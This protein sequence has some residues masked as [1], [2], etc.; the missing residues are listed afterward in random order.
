MAATVSL[1]VPLLRHLLLACGGIPAENDAVRRSLREGGRL[2]IVP[3][4][5]AEMF[6]PD[7][8]KKEEVVLLAS[9]KGFVRLALETGRDLIPVYIFGNSRVF[10]LAGIS[11][12]LESVSRW[13]KTSLV[14]FYGRLG[15]P[16][17]FRQ[18]L[19]YAIGRPIRVPKPGVPA[20]V[21]QDLI[22]RV[23]AE[24]VCAVRDLYDRYK[25]AYGW[26]DRPL[27]IK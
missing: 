1:Y 8:D 12:W 5:I 19:L 16:I 4:G 2:F 11:K 23:H 24:F 22:D 25:G 15:L 13:L 9:R 18:R 17:P 20:P 21:P 3:G 14:F 7:L 27:V 6:V 10:G 26:S